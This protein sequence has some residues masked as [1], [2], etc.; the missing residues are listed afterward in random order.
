MMTC[1]KAPLPQ[2][3]EHYFEVTFDDSKGTRGDKLKKDSTNSCGM[4]VGLWCAPEPCVGTEN[5]ASIMTFGKPFWGL[6]G[7]KDKDALRVRGKGSG[8]VGLNSSGWAISNG[9]TVGV[10]VNMDSA[11]MTF[12]RDGHPI[13][14][15]II[16]GFEKTD[17]RIAA[18]CFTIMGSVTLTR[19]QRGEE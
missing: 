11:S 17:A 19:K 7:D 14:D 12:F 4:A 15:A 18:C 9:D 1:A 8:K 3:G 2:T 13:P 6:R 16:R 5:A 10:L